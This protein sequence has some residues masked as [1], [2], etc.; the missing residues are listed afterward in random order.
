[1][2]KL[3]N[4]NQHHAQVGTVLGSMTHVSSVGFGRIA[5]VGCCS[6]EW[7]VRV[8]VCFSEVDCMQNATL[9]VTENE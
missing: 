8:G 4:E 7:R 9:M 5:R 6:A 2:H 1:M 3:C